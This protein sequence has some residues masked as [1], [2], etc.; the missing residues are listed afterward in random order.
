MGGRN[1]QEK[2]SNIHVINDATFVLTETMMYCLICETVNISTA[3]R[4]GPGGRL[5]SSS[6]AGSLAP[7]LSA[8]LCEDTVTAQSTRGSPG[9]WP[10][11]AP[12]LPGVLAPHKVVIKVAF[13]GRGIP[14]DVSPGESSSCGGTGSQCPSPSAQPD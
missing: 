1:I 12:G 14:P 4:G 10:E 13:E 3:P 9:L 6:R 8:Y 2:S 11:C 7:L 5:P